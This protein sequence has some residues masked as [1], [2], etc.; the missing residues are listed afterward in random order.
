M[1]RI[2]VLDDWQDLARTYADW[3]P[4][5]ARAEVVFFNTPFADADAVAKALEGFDI[6]LS[7]R[8]RTHFPA[9]LIARLPNLKMF[10]LTGK[11]VGAI[12]LAALQAR[13]IPITYTGGGE[14][15]ASTAEL[16]LTLMLAAVRRIPQGD[17]AV[18][19]GRFMQGVGAGYELKGRTLGL[20]GVGRIGGLMAGYCRAI[21]MECIGWSP[22]LTPEKAQAAG[23]AAVS[24]E[25]L[26]ARAD[27]I[28]LHLVLS[29]R[30]RGTLT[31]P[32]FARMK[33]GAV[34]VNTSRAPLIDEAALLDAVRAGRIIAALD[35]YH[36]EPPRPDNPLLGA[37]NTVLSPHI[38]YGVDDIYKVFYAQQIEN[39]LGFLDGKPVRVLEPV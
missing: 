12:D 9:S 5:T 36:E 35:V 24:K 31:A 32:D 18:R 15:G 3:S 38:G 27:V 26:L 37:P 8:E 28:S 17:A 14:N 39:A 34:L 21:G 29:D 25:E 2:A 16:A 1:T 11:R 6:V 23:V 7:M 33:Q 19:A 22:N 10:G 13:G 4:L 30:T 20:I